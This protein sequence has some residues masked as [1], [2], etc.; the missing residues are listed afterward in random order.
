MGAAWFWIVLATLACQVGI[1][2]WANRRFWQFW[3]RADVSRPARR[4]AAPDVV[5]ALL[6][7][8]ACYEV[9]VGI[10]GPGLG[11]FHPSASTISLAADVEHGNLLADY[12]VAAH[13]VGHAL[14]RRD[15]RGLIILSGWLQTASPLVLALGVALA[16]EA[17]IAVRPG[18]FV[19]G[20]I[21]V[22]TSLILGVG[23]M[24]LELDASR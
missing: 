19:A 4:P 12:A 21:A 24:L 10:G 14:Q 23:I 18:L 9:K 1:A 8:A 17:L 15:R 22:E 2:L 6:A 7:H 11:A 16:T 5:H 3:Q 13:E 20:V